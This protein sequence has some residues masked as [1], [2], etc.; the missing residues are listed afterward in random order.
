MK[1]EQRKPAAQLHRG[2]IIDGRGFFVSRAGTLGQ[3]D[4]SGEMKCGLKS[5]ADFQKLHLQ[6]LL[7]IIL[8]LYIPVSN[9]NRIQESLA[10]LLISTQEL[11]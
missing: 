7:G 1:A 9:A 5:T 10:S 2:N 4:E 3:I 6:K 8:P 11:L